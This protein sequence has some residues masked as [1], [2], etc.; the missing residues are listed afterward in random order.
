[1]PS[2][3]SEQPVICVLYV[4]PKRIDLPSTKLDSAA[5]LQRNLA[6]NNKIANCPSLSCGAQPGDRPE[7]MATARALAHEL[8]AANAKLVYGGGTTGLMGEV[9]RTLVSLSGP[10][11]VNGF[12]PRALVAFYP[13]AAGGVPSG[14]AGKLLQ[15]E[16]KQAERVVS[17]GDEASIEGDQKL[18]SSLA[19]GEYG[20]ITLVDSMHERKQRMAEL[21]LA[22]GPGS[23]FVALPGGYG[24]LEEVTEVIT[25]NQLGIHDRGIILL[26]IN[27]FWDGVVAWI[28]MAAQRKFIGAANKDIAVEC[29]EVEQVMRALEEYRPSGGRLSLSWGCK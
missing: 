15:E 7:Y 12:I 8:H 6:C 26:N 9:A 22:G 25:W 1:M 14:V 3:R 4:I 23:G 2:D 27:G 5:L 29:K 24:T 13:E 17:R 21:V 16:R 18:G 11:A 20:R 10:S 28:A 19:E